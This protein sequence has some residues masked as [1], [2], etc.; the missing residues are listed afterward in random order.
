MLCELGD[1]DAAWRE[2]EALSDRSFA[3][4]PRD[5]L[6]LAAAAHLAEVTASLGAV[7][8]AA[9][10]YDLLAP[11]AARNVVVGWA[12]TCLGSAARLLAM[13]ASLLDREEEAKCHFERALAMN[14]SMG[15]EPWVTRT[16][17]EY[18]RFLIAS[19]HGTS[20]A[21]ALL[22]RALADARRLGMRPVLKQARGLVAT[23]TP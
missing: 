5:G 17:V 11:F 16:R 9:E 8:H 15:A 4:I 23:L 14:E 3:A 12:S 1:R 21:R 13:L 6:W 22:E 18:A 19:G 10:L 2:L 7:K 20:S